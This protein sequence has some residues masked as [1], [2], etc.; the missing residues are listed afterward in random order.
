[1]K[2]VQRQKDLQMGMV[3]MTIQTMKA[4]LLSYIK[5]LGKII[6]ARTKQLKNVSK[7]HKI[8]TK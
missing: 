3:T 1:M 7:L 5:Y 6:K 4:M 8:K 2:Q